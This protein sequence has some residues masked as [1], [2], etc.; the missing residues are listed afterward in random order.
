MDRCCFQDRKIKSLHSFWEM[1]VRRGRWQRDL[2]KG[3][4]PNRCRAFQVRCWKRQLSGTHCAN[5]E[6]VFHPE[7][8]IRAEDTGQRSLCEL[9]Y[10]AVAFRKVSLTI[11]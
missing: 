6:G 10:V 9:G 4:A 2:G 8:F 1:V 3:D 11:K 5:S 7:D